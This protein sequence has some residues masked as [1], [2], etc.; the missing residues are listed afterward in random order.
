MLRSFLQRLKSKKYLRSRLAR[1]RMSCNDHPGYA[2]ANVSYIKYSDCTSLLKQV[3]PTEVDLLVT[4]AT[5]A[6]GVEGEINSG[7]VFQQQ[8]QQRLPVLN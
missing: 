4:P 2:C 6:V 7:L 3:Q 8:L 1:F 5:D